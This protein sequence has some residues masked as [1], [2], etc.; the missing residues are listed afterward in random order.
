MDFEN[1]RVP[2]LKGHTHLAATVPN[3]Q[4]QNVPFYNVV[5]PAYKG[6]AKIF[7][8]YPVKGK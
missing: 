8:K 4:V 1:Q 3:L 6:V 5:N 7:K 2:V